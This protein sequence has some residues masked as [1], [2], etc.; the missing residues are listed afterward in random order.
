MRVRRSGPQNLPN[1][2]HQLRVW[3]YPVVVNSCAVTNHGSK[4]QRDI[5]V[6]SSIAQLREFFDADRRLY[7]TTDIPMASEIPSIH[8]QSAGDPRTRGYSDAGKC[9]NEKFSHDLTIAFPIA[10]CRCGG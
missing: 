1:I 7:F 6:H 10:A 3:I 9:C 2:L 5:T 8:D 4:L